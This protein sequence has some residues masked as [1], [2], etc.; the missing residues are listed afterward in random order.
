MKENLVS[1][2]IPAYNHENYVQE[3]INSIINQ[4]YQNIELI[5]VDDGSS[6]STWQK[7]CALEDKCKERFCNISFETQENEGTCATLNKLLSKAQGEFVYFIASDDIAKPEAIEIELDFLKNNPNY[8]LVVGN[9]EIIDYDG[10]IC[11]WDKKRNIEYNKNKA[12][13][14]TFVD[15]AKVKNKYFDNEKFGTYS[16]L[17]MGNYIPNGYLIRKNVLDKIPKFTTKAPLEDWFMM[18][19]L[20]KYTKF[21]YIDKILFSYRW[22]GKNAILN[23]EKIQKFAALTRNFES[24]IIQQLDL[25]S[26]REDVAQTVENG[27]LYKKKG[28]PY[29]F[30]ILKYKKYHTEKEITKK[31]IKLFNVKI[32]S[33]TKEF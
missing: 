14:K 17:Y 15:H 20:S 27:A 29:I 28:I 33:K 18:L 12:K 30:E 26:S 9:S 23:K 25:S 21:K 6:D 19:Q 5:I 24:Q 8:G 32:F 7:I 13:Y 11:Y 16:T 1:V 22:H 31:E 3:T 2:I 4:T 10:K